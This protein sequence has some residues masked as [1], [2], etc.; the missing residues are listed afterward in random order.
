[1]AFRYQ[2]TSR[3]AEEEMYQA[4]IDAAI[5]AEEAESERQTAAASSRKRQTNGT[6]KQVK[7]VPKGKGKAKEQVVEILSGSCDSDV[8]FEQVATGQLRV[9]PDIRKVACSA[10]IRKRQRQETQ[11]DAY[12]FC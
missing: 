2:Q 8:E 9:H 5:A 1:M 7:N 10:F 11:F 12:T 4:E 6:S 3:E